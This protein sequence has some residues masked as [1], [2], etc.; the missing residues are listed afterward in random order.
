MKLRCPS[1][2]LSTRYSW[3]GNEI[4]RDCSIKRWWLNRLGKGMRS[5][6]R[7]KKRW[8][9]TPLSMNI[10]WRQVSRSA[11]CNKNWLLMP[12]RRIRSAT[13]WLRLWR[14]LKSRSVRLRGR[15]WWLECRWL[16]ISS[17][18]P[19]RIPRISS[20]CCTMEVVVM[21]LTTPFAWWL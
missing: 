3:R 2:R 17:T 20:S 5:P 12:Q 1:E 7:N 9:E 14:R 4:R 6:C 13:T 18:Q 16:V 11:P 8:G 21:W 10:S 15:T 19:F